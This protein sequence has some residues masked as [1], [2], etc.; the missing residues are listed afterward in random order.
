MNFIYSIINIYKDLNQYKLKSIQKSSNF[1]LQNLNILWNNKII[2]GYSLKNDFVIIYFKYKN[3]GISIIKK[4]NLVSKPGKRIFKGYKELPNER[5][6]LFILNTSHGIFDH[7]SVI[8][9][10]IGGEVL[11]K[12]SL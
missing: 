1:L 4:I 12:I 9:K 3:N 5:K 8:K 10:K 7:R 11:I 6:T 2:Y